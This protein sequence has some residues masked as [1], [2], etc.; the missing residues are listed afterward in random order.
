MTDTEERT[1]TFD[2]LSERAKD[3]ARDAIRY[4]DVHDDWWD[5][6]YED[7]VNMGIEINE[8]K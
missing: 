2:E 3:T 8:G 5:A 7:A 6:V 4:D 1:Y